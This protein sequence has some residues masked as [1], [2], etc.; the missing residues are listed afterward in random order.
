MT[1]RLY[2]LSLSHPARATRLAL[3][4][5]RVD[6]E[7]IDLLPGM[8]PVA[9]KAHGFRRATVPALKIDGR[10]VQGSLQIARYL[11]QTRPDPPL[12]PSGAAERSAVEEAERW[13]EAELQ[14]IPRR[15]F[16]YLATRNQALRMWLVDEV[17]GLPLPSLASRA[18]MPV[19]F[20]L[21]RVVG[22]TEP[23]VRADVEGL[24]ATLDHVDRLIADRVIGTGQPNAAD[25]QVLTTIRL[26]EGLPD[27]LPLLEGRAALEAARRLMPPFPG[28]APPAVPAEWLERAQARR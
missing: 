27:F 5:K 1:A 28:P 2:S 9:V 25:F 24:P 12:Y 19:A 17:V 18:N 16:R 10:R 21:G 15:V 8:H 20:M 3:E 11:E 26:L 23:R 13:G 4:H 6:H 7:V 22:A 14:P